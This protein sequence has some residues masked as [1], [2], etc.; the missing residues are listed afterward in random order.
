MKKH[1]LN[2]LVIISI[3]FVVPVNSWSLFGYDPEDCEATKPKQKKAEGDRYSIHSTGVPLRNGEEYAYT[4]DGYLAGEIFNIV[5]AQNGSL[6]SAYT[7]CRSAINS[8]WTQLQ[9]TEPRLAAQSVDGYKRNLKM[10]DETRMS[11]LQNPSLLKTASNSKM[12]KKKD[13]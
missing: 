1:Y 8:S 9:R 10:C 7:S 12:Y 3:L 2:L 11:Y 4:M 5:L 6:G 13:F